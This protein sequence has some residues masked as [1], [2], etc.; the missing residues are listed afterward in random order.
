MGRM[1][2]YL[3]AQSP[4]MGRTEPISPETVPKYESEVSSFSETSAKFR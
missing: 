3:L 2:L 4:Y 1:D